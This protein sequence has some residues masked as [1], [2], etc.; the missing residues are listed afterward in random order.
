MPKTLGGQFL[1]VEV[2]VKQTFGSSVLLGSGKIK[3]SNVPP[4]NTRVNI[5]IYDSHGHQT[6]VVETVSRFEPQQNTASAAVNNFR[7]A[8]TPTPTPAANIP[9][10]VANFRPAATAP[11]PAPAKPPRR[12]SAPIVH[13][14]LSDLG[15]NIASL[16]VDEHSPGELLNFSQQQ[17]QQ[18][19]NPAAP[20][21]DLR[22]P[23]VAKNSNLID[24]RNR[25]TTTAPISSLA[26]PPTQPVNPT[27]TSP[28]PAAVNAVHASNLSE[29]ISM[30]FSQEAAESALAQSNDILRDAVNM[31]LGEAPTPPAAPPRT[32]QRRVSNANMGAVYDYN[33]GNGGAVAAPSRRTS[34]PA[35]RVMYNY[36][37]NP[38]SNIAPVVVPQ[39]IATITNAVPVNS[40]APRVPTA[41]AAMP[42]QVGGRRQMKH[43]WEERRDERT[44]RFYYLNHATQTTSW[45]HPGWS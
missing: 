19:N 22:K 45:K 43:G 27:Q 24:L 37:S 40:P 39:N 26:R 11:A 14:Q 32:S 18:Q 31:L 44:G 29:L 13:R 28:P 34:N 42:T 20:I 33:S 21:L 41:R 8:P 12:G 16:T 2:K 9:A 7:P 36:D 35:P 6:G 10:P 23:S 1:F 3:A 25:G 4:S 17:Q 5:P 30:G 38:S 15:Q